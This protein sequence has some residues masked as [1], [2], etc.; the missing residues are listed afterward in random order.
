[1]S[2]LVSLMLCLAGVLWVCPAAEMISDSLRWAVYPR[3]AHGGDQ[4]FVVWEE[5]GHVRGA[6][7][8]D[9]TL[10]V[11]HRVTVT[12][13]LGVIYDVE[14]AAVGTRFLVVWRPE[15]NDSGMTRTEIICKSIDSEGNPGLTR[16]VSP[17]GVHAITPTVA[18]SDT[19][20]FVAYKVFPV[21]D[22]TIQ[23]RRVSIHGEAGEPEVTV[24]FGAFPC[25]ASD[26]AGFLVSYIYWN[27][28][29][30]VKAGGGLP[31][32]EIFDAISEGTPGMAGCSAPDTFLVAFIDTSGSL[33]TCLCGFSEALGDPIVVSP[34]LAGDSLDVS[35]GDFNYLLA[36]QPGVMSQVRGRRHD[37]AGAMVG[38]EADVSQPAGHDPHVASRG[39]DYAVV[40]QQVDDTSSVI[41]IDTFPAYQRHFYSGSA[42]ATAFNQSRHIARDP[43]TGDLHVV[44]MTGEPETQDSV[45]YTRSTNNGEDWFPY[46]YVGAGRYPA[47]IV[48]DVGGGRGPWVAYVTADSSLVQAIRQGEGDWSY[49]TIFDALPVEQSVGPP[50]YA[51]CYLAPQEDVPAACAAYPV[52][53][54]SGDCWI[55]FSVSTQLGVEYDTVVRVSSTADFPCV[56]VTPGDIAH[57]SWQEGEEAERAIYYM[58]YGEGGWSDTVRVSTPAPQEPTSEPADHA[59]LEAYGDFVYCVWR[60]PADPG[61][62]WR[63]SRWLQNPPQQWY[64]PD[65]QNCTAD[66]ESDYPVMTTEYVSV[67]HEQVGVGGNYDIWARYVDRPAPDPLCTT[68]TR[69]WFPH[70]TSYCEEEPPRFHCQTVWTEATDNPEMFEV[71]FCDTGPPSAFAEG[72]EPGSF[73]AVEVGGPKPSPYCTRRGGFREYRS[74]RADTSASELTYVLPYLSPRCTY[75]LRAVFYH[76]GKETWTA[77][78]RGDSATWTRVAFR[79]NVPE[80]VWIRIPQQAYR[81]DARIEFSLRKVSGGFVSLAGLKLFQREFRDKGYELAVF[82][83]S[84]PSVR[85][86]RASPNP[87]RSQTAVRYGLALPGRARVDIL[88][89][90]GRV[91]CKLVDAELA[92][93][94]HRAAW[95][96]RDERGRPVAAGVY[97]CRLQTPDA[98]AI[99]RVVL[100]R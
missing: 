8:D 63:G 91:V 38:P 78:L 83:G 3:I 4:Y 14:V 40:W 24:P 39:S 36:W 6:L 1:M 18:G 71:V 73:Y 37:F 22:P 54:S 100:L 88:D 52:Y 66:R 85:Q 56:A 76:E 45:L 99:D 80:T 86:L 98:A 44:Y 11:R 60:G 93:G 92:A 19:E 34:N 20:Y 47:V 33:R 5:E 79:P 17:P 65:T 32:Y 35:S 59:S 49:D 27:R 21:G 16:N 57:V 87:F 95:K 96:G 62:V 67:W 84:A 94:E 42:H 28:L 15:F 74:F 41:Y 43:V 61:D 72:H 13:T 29:R 12:D 23:G 7:L 90:T 89:A 30:A 10:E 46:E 25:V 50:S 31:P 51:P 48:N 53:I 9:S 26:G 64:D 58:A 97:F 77:E 2:K 70:V 68:E 75:L 82:G 81:K 69:S 55:H